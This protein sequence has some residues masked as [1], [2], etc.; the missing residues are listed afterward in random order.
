MKT[1][2]K[3]AKLQKNGKYMNSICF[4]VN[5]HRRTHV[6]L[7]LWFI[8]VACSFIL[9]SLSHC[10]AQN[11][12]PCESSCNFEV[13]IKYLWIFNPQEQKKSSLSTFNTWNYSK[14]FMYLLLKLKKELSRSSDSWMQNEIFHFIIIIIQWMHVFMFQELFNIEWPLNN[15]PSSHTISISS[16]PILISQIQELG[17]PR[18]LVPHLARNNDNS[19]LPLFKILQWQR[20]I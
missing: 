9:C 10:S 7:D 15:I 3:Q 8:P 1:K 12:E 4:N 18:S 11:E 14:W 6:F 2:K 19:L 17:I 5:P 16:R 20:A 13:P